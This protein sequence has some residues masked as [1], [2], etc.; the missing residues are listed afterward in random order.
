MSLSLEL[1]NNVTG[2]QKSLAALSAADAAELFIS[3]WVE[4]RILLLATEESGPAMWIVNRSDVYDA[5]L[6]KL[7]Q[8]SLNEIA[9]R[10]KTKLSLRHSSLSFL[11]PPVLDGPVESIPDREAEDVLGHPLCSFE[12]ILFFS[13]SLNEDLR[14]SSALSLTRRLLEHPPNWTGHEQLRDFIRER[15]V[16][17]LSE[18]SSPYVRA[19]VARVPL[20]D[21]E[22]LLSAFKKEKNPRVLGRILQNPSSSQTLLNVAVDF[23]PSD[24]HTQTILA[25]DERLTPHQ[26]QHLLKR[27][28]ELTLPFYVHNYFLSRPTT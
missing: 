13:K 4:S 21:P 2:I 20:L 23:V 19:Y 11:E 27:V 24:I 7:T 8:H 1:G 5:T 17:L 28:P 9:L 22:S 15:Y 25:L 16:T 26:R 3:P 6:E 10:A 14:A 12:A 18:D